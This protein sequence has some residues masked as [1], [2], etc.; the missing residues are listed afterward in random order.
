[1]SVCGGVLLGGIGA[2]GCGHWKVGGGGVSS[3]KEG[4]REP[5]NAAGPGPV[6]QWRLPLTGSVSY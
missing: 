2:D 3:V 4:G 5:A 1:M 6:V